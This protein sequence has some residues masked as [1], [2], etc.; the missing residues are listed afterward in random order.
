MYICAEGIH[1]PLGLYF[2]IYVLGGF[3]ENDCL[4]ELPLWVLP[5]CFFWL[6]CFL[7]CVQ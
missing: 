6:A 5:D 3:C 4:S 2:V 1:M 7:I